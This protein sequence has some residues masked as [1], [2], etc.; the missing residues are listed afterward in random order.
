[1]KKL[2]F[3]ILILSFSALLNGDGLKLWPQIT[4]GIVNGEGRQAMNLVIGDDGLTVTDTCYDTYQKEGL[5]KRWNVDMG[6]YHYTPLKDYKFDKAWAGLP[7]SITV[8][9]YDPKK[10]GDS[11]NNKASVIDL[12]ADTVETYQ[13]ILILGGEQKTVKFPKWFSIPK[14]RLAYDLDENPAWP[15]DWSL[16]KG[17]IAIFQGCAKV[18]QKDIDGVNPWLRFGFT[19]IYPHAFS[20]GEGHHVPGREQLGGLFYDN[21]W[22]NMENGKYQKGSDPNSWHGKV[23]IERAKDMSIIFPVFAEC[24]WY[25][26]EDYQYEAF[27]KI[28]DNTREAYPD[29]MV[30]CWGVGPVRRSFRVF[31]DY[32]EKG[33]GLGI[34][35]EIT[36]H[37]WVELYKD[38][39]IK[40]NTI[41]HGCDL[42]FGT[43]NANYYNNAKPSQLYAVLQEFEN[44]KIIKPNDKN[45]MTF[46]IQQ[47]FVDGYPQ[48]TYTFRNSK[49]EWRQANMTHQVPASQVYA[50]SL[51]GHCVMDGLH[52][53]D[54]GTFYSEDPDE[55]YSWEK[56]ESQTKISV[57]GEEVACNYYVKYFG[58]YNYHVLGMWQASQNKDIIEADTK[59]F[60][61]EYKSSKNDIWRVGDEVFPS[62][63]S[64]HKEPLI[65]A[66]L[67]SDGKELLVIADNPFNEGCERVKIRIPDSNRE[68]TFDLVGDWP[69]IKRFSID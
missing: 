62:L 39:N 5:K 19:H 49:G 56:G 10:L 51:F 48:T 52:C 4:R 55:Y 15:R 22:I 61:P 41:Y 12:S 45:V 68:F 67:S 14:D 3:M 17:K 33:D 26:W 38:P 7:V 57:N 58:F 40:K 18:R 13:E 35:N 24:G 2:F 47:Q 30:G 32:D 59:W 11:V 42:N 27:K 53:W 60:M 28:I 54:V 63:A 65:R 31:D 46:W 25:N 9:L 8:E 29:V 16:P 23:F 37:K 50:M 64:F 34:T 36:A 20:K 69:Q 6:E 1:M 43:P 21:E 66:K 44:G